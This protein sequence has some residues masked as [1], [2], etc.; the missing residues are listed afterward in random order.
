MVDT[1]LDVP[2]DISVT[3]LIAMVQLNKSKLISHTMSRNTS[4]SMVQMFALVEIS[5]PTN[6]EMIRTQ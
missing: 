4:N 1:I 5:T 2:L 3:I 6:V